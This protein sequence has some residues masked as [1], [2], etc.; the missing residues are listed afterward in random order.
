MTSLNNIEARAVNTISQSSEEILSLLEIKAHLRIDDYMTA[1][2]S[3]ITDILLPSAIEYCEDYTH[4]AIGSKQYE[5][6]LDSFPTTGKD[7]IEMPL[8]PLITIDSIKYKDSKGLIY[9]MDTNTYFV[10]SDFMPGKV[11]LNYNRYWPMYI[12]SPYSSVKIRFTAGHSKE[13]LPL[14]IKQAI[15]LIIGHLY[16]H[17]EEVATDKKIE[18]I[19]FGVDALLWP[20]R[21]F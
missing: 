3:Y 18:Q 12:P 9:D 13:D 20:L 1:D 2:D 10:D 11:C 4:R 19:P 14:R 6:I 21:I 15:L 8:S 16:E 17:R 5:L 7:F